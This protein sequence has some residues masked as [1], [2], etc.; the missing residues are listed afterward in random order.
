MTTEVGGM[1]V[2][3]ATAA[4]EKWANEGYSWALCLNPVLDSLARVPPKMTS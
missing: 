3:E 4:S 1:S 2:T